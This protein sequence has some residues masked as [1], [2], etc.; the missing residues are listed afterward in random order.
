MK[1]AEKSQVWIMSLNPPPTTLD[2]TP[3]ALI[4]LPPRHF[5]ETS[6]NTQHTVISSLFVENLNSVT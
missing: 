4:D 3:P 1:G 6:Q 5:E 2:P